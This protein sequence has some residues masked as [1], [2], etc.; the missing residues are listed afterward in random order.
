MRNEVFFV[1]CERSQS[2]NSY[3]VVGP[4]CAWPDVVP[5][6]QN[7]GGCRPAKVVYGHIPGRHRDLPLQVLLAFSYPLQA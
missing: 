2:E 1:L 7:E 5:I 3:S 4:T 6:Y